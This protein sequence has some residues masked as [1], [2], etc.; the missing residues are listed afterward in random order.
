MLFIAVIYF[1]QCIIFI[2]VMDFTEHYSCWW[3][4]MKLMN[5]HQIDELSSGR[6]LFIRLMIFYTM[7]F[8]QI[9][10]ILTDWWIFI[11]IMNFHR[12]YTSSLTWLINIRVLIFITVINFYLSDKFSSASDVVIRLT[13]FQLTICFHHCLK[14][15]F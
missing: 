9:D 8:H 10:E 15:S 12:G 3:I 13:K 7:N 5:L 1:H 14:F 4:F 2:K 6:L 11:R